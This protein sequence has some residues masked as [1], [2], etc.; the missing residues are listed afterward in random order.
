MQEINKCVIIIPQLYDYERRNEMSKKIIALVSLLLAFMMLATL[1][2]SC[3]DDNSKETE[4]KTENKDPSDTSIKSGIPEG[5]TFEGETIEWLIWSD[6]TMD[7]FYVDGLNGDEINDAIWERN[8]DIQKQYGVTFNYSES[9]GNSDHIDEYI[10]KVQM[11]FQGDQ[12]Y[13]IIA[14]YSLIPITL[15]TRGYIGNMKETKYLDFSKPWWPK[16]MVDQATINNKLYFCAGDISTNMLWMMHVL[17]YNKDLAEDYNMPNLYELVDGP[18]W[19]QEKLIELSMNVYEDKDRDEKRDAED[20]YGLG[21]CGMAIDAF[22]AGAGILSVTKD[23]GTDLFAVGPDFFGEKMVNVIDLGLRMLDSNGTYYHKQSQSSTRVH[24]A[25][26]NS[27]FWADRVFAG[28]REFQKEGVEVTFGVLPIPKF[29]SDQQEYYTGLGHPFSLYCVSS[30]VIGEEQM[31]KVSAILQEMSFRSYTDVTPQVFDV[32]LKNRYAEEP[33]DA[34]MLD[35]IK[36]N[37]VFEM[38]RFLNKEIGSIATD[39]YRTMVI[40]GQN[41]WSS[42][43][44]KNS[45]ALAKELEAINKLWTKEN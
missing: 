6:V 3:K 36:D 9:K 41:T 35:L 1:L 24:F 7:E 15:A 39:G 34:R 8:E 30:N 4:S 19:T 40:S 28:A 10:N 29:N 5:L 20:L 32:T 21:V 22:A 27:L 18:D 43:S 42:T 45:V 26:G 12:S 33:D 25:N 31:D 23:R 13:E 44:R 38:G 14:A 11:D 37:V 16:N 17:F 2:V